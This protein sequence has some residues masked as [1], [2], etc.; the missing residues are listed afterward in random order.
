MHESLFLLSLIS[1]IFLVAGM[2]KG[3]TG[4]GLPTVAMSLLGMLMSPASA[5]ALLVI[6]SF[7][8][9][10]W[11]CF[12]GPAIG[13]LL[14]R[15]WPLIVTI[16]V[17]TLWGSSLLANTAPQ[18]SGMA[19]GIALLIYAGY[20]LLA[21]ALTI[22]PR[23]EP[24]LSPLIGLVTGIVTGITGVFV[25]PAVPYLQALNLDKDELVQAL[26]LSFTVST[27]ALAGGLFM[28]DV[29]R[30]NQ[31]GMSTLVILPSLLGMWLG[32]KIRVHISPRRFKQ[33]LLLFL[34]V[35]GLQLIIRPFI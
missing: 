11:Q 33:C 26:G 32:Q 24:W 20:A 23:L 22:P 16:V 4:M 1:L 28:H 14:R 3:I 19:L 31:L 25:M 5:A 30:L 2:V 15:L 18:L 10:V 29:F 17:G 12:S 34:A 7:V 6:P 8:T 9:N 13:S 27:L 21:P 35:L